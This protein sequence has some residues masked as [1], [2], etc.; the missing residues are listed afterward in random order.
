MNNTS[1]I[2]WLINYKKLAHVIMVA[3]KS[4]DLQLARWRPGSTS[5]V[6]PGHI[7]RPESQG[8]DGASSR[9]QAA[10]LQTQ[11]RINF[12]VKAGKDQCPNS[13]VRQAEFLL[14]LFVLFRSQLLSEPIRIR[15]AIHFT[16]STSLGVNLTQK[17]PHRHSQNNVWP[18]VCTPWSSWPMN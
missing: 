14:S 9:L 5:G 18:N 15:E 7:Q 6:V 8:A 1:L 3:E 12:S 16:Q 13:P 17:H 2:N 10:G 4:Q 11:K